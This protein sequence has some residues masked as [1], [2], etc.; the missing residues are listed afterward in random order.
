VHHA[1]EIFRHSSSVQSRT[2]AFFA[3]PSRAIVHSDKYVMSCRV[4]LKL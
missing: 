3:M 2:A 4:C 1:G